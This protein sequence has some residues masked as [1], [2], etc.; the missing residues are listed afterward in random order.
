MKNKSY[1]AT[2]EVALSPADV[3]KHINDVAKWWAK[4]AD[5]SDSGRKTEFEGQSTRL[6]D[7]FIVRSGDRH[8]S[9]QKLVEFIPDK[10][11]VW[12]VTESKLNWIEKNKDEWTKTKMIFEIS[13][14]ADKTILNFTHEGLVP[15]QECYFMCAPGW[16]MF[17]KKSLYNFM[18][19]SKK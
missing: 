11:V 7:E 19:N 6:N 1:T 15:E 8:Y 2:I 3:F 10:K 12:L 18:T 9:K 5:E 13:S 4:S 16:D 14:K 17:I